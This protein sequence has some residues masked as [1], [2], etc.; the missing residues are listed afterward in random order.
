LQNTRWRLVHQTSRQ[1][2]LSADGEV[3]G[4]HQ[5]WGNTYC[6]CTYAWMHGHHPS[7][8]PCPLQLRLHGASTRLCCNLIV[9]AKQRLYWHGGFMT[10][11]APRTLQLLSF[12]SVLTDLCT[13][14]TLVLLQDSQGCSSNTIAVSEH[15]LPK[16]MTLIKGCRLG[17]T[18]QPHTIPLSTSTQ[19][20]RQQ[21][22]L[23]PAFGS[24]SE[25]GSSRGD[26]R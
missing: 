5:A 22:G 25:W 16:G 26:E 23:L 6:T 7:T 24:T 11:S 9:I 20:S 17:G 12:N 3:S 19:R 15:R 10:T 18:V 21:V 2:R 8:R 4:G 13:V 14:C 1:K